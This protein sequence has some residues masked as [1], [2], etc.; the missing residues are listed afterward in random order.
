MLFH[1]DRDQKDRE[2]LIKAAQALNEAGIPFNLAGCC[3]GS[4]QITLL[5]PYGEAAC[6][7]Y[8][9]RDQG[10]VCEAVE[11]QQGDEAE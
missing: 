6:T 4:L 8:P 10:M 9:T 11:P 1:T 5:D 2:R 7:I 3:E